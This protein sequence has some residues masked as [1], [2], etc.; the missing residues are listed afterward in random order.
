M[1]LFGF[2]SYSLKVK[3]EKFL[4]MSIGKNFIEAI[5]QV[6]PM[7]KSAASAIYAIGRS[8]SMI[9]ITPDSK[10][11]IFAVSSSECNNLSTENNYQNLLILEVLKG[12]LLTF[13]WNQFARFDEEYALYISS[14]N[15][16]RNLWKIRGIDSINAKIGHAEVDWLQVR[17][18]QSLLN[19][20]SVGLL[21]FSRLLGRVLLAFPYFV[22]KNEYIIPMP[23]SFMFNFAMTVTTSPF[24]VN[25]V[26]L[27]RFLESPFLFNGIS[28][29]VSIFMYY[30]MYY[31]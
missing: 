12:S 22:F 11:V 3:F 19:I 23:A 20:K 16:I 9:S 29:K 18:L 5:L 27:K 26:N 28:N 10:R 15:E 7:E 24:I 13:V 31:I 4:I 25:V 8:L 30:Y 14:S 17:S 6:E 1:F 21:T 2:S